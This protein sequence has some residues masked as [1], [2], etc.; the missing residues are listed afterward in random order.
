MFKGVVIAL[1][2][3]LIHRKILVEL[4]STGVYAMVKVTDASRC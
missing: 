1:W 3:M 2:M 4:I